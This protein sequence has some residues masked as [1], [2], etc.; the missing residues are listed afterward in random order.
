MEAVKKAFLQDVYAIVGKATF[1]SIA[2]P[3][4]F[5]LDDLRQFGKQRL[6]LSDL[7]KKGFEVGAQVHEPGDGDITYTITD[8]KDG[9]AKLTGG[10]ED[11]EGRV[12][13]VIIG[14]LADSYEAVGNATQSRSSS[15]PS[16]PS[17]PFLSSSPCLF[18]DLGP[19]SGEERG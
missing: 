2:P 8:L 6:S 3:L 4:H 18:H 12:T 7:K 19:L 1:E 14:R 5:D 9:V 11:S 15:T 17:A 16:L 10:D 13:E